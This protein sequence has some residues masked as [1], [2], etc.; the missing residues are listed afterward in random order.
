MRGEAKERW[1]HLCEMAANEQD[2]E[3]LVELVSEINR[4]LEEKEQRL[5]RARER[6]C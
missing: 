4:I 3:K 1:M 5:K 2:P 6:H